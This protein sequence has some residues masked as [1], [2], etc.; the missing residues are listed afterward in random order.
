MAKCKVLHLGQGKPKHKYRLD[1][2]GVESSPEVKDLG[3]LVDKKL[4]R[5]QQHVT[6]AQKAICV[7]GCIKSSVARRLR[8]AIVPLCCALVRAHVEHCIQ[9][10]GPHQK[11]GVD[12]L[13]QVQRRAMKMITELEH[14]AYENKLRESWGFQHGEE[15][16]LWRGYSSLF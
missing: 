3:V 15:K 14:P 1:G 12:L 7:L 10:Q 16:A 8:E 2:E 6:A 13:A 9:L 5:T 4:N 11:K